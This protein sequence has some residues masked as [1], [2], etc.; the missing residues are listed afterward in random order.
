MIHDLKNNSPFT[1]VIG[2]RGSYT[3]EKILGLLG[4]K[5]N[6]RFTFQAN[7]FIVPLDECKEKLINIIRNLEGE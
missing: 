1:N 6:D 3:V 4:L 2:G 7:K 5:E